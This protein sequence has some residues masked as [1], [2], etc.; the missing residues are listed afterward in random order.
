MNLLKFYFQTLHYLAPTMAAKQVYKVMSNPR[1]RKLRPHEESVLEKAQKAKIKFKNFDIQTYIWGAPNN[2]K[3][4]LVHG[5]EG[6][7]GNFSAIVELLLEKGYQ[8]ISFDGPA[9]GKSTIAPTTMFEFGDFVAE[10]VQQHLPQLIISHSFGS[11]TSG[12]ALNQNPNI[13]VDMWV[14]ITTP[15][16]FKDRIKSVTEPLGVT[17]KIRTKLISLIEEN[18]GEKVEELNMTAYCSRLTNVKEALI[19]HSKSDKVLPIADARLVHKA[20]PQSKLVELDNLGHY[21]ILW[22]E[23]IKEVLKNGIK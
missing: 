21:S 10:M 17:D 1:I 18:T 22:S 6:Q 19:I 8:V 16:H 4:L 13:K 20:M 14:L 5:W 23:E 12:N 3:A 2:K 9:H 15:H 7:A 11:V